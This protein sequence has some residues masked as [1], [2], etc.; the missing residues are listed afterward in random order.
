MVDS[1]SQAR[2]WYHGDFTQQLCDVDGELSIAKWQTIH[3]KVCEG[4][5]KERLFLHGLLRT[6]LQSGP[7]RHAFCTPPPTAITLFVGGRKV[8]FQT[9]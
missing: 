9:R 5:L 2:G 3:G 7:A 6:F 8:G 1:T 4:D